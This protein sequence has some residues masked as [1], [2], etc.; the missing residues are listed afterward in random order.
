MYGGSKM[1]AIILQY[2]YVKSTQTFMG[3]VNYV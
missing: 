3:H 1:V 2:M